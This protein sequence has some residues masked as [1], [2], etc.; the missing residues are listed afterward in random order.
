LEQNGRRE[1]LEI[2]G[3]AMGDDQETPQEV[4][5]KFFLCFSTCG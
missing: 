1:N 5:K 3:V 4:E 2:Q